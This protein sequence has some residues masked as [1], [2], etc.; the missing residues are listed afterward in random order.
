MI[1]HR[2]LELPFPL[3]EPTP[4]RFSPPIGTNIWIEALPLFKER[5]AFNYHIKIINREILPGYLDSIAPYIYELH[6]EIEDSSLATYV[7]DLKRSVKRYLGVAYEL[8]QMTRVCTDAFFKAFNIKAHYWP[9][10]KVIPEESIALLV[11]KSNPRTAIWIKTLYTLGRTIEE[12]CSLRKENISISDSKMATA[13]IRAKGGWKDQISIPRSLIDEIETVCP[14]SE[15]LLE[16]VRGFRYAPNSVSNMI[17]EASGRLLGKPIRSHVFRH[18]FATYSVKYHIEKANAI[19]R[20]GGWKD[21]VVF[22]S[23]YVEHKMEIEDFP[24][25]GQA[26]SM[27]RNVQEELKNI[28][29]LCETMQQDIK[30]ILDMQMQVKLAG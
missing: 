4:K 22:W 8:D 24:V 1:N 16:S 12:L 2:Q 30:D 17:A 19:M 29:T 3:F 20:Q 10:P 15:F 28:K 13:Q 14:G 23:T 25:I 27:R 11:R 7:T 5:K 9:R 26:S 6:G 21:G 18:C